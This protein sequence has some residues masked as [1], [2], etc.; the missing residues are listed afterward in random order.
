[1]P[2]ECRSC[3][4]LAHRR[5][6]FLIMNALASRKICAILNVSCATMTL[7]GNID[8]INGCILFVCARSVQPLL[9]H[10][11]T[12]TTKPESTRARLNHK[13]NKSMTLAHER[14]TLSTECRDECAA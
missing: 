12:T 1:M 9:R 8:G 2:T 11:P 7:D 14:C 5:A 6:C 4:D 10:Y 3:S 13:S